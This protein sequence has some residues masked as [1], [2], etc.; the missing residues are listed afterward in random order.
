MRKAYLSIDHTVVGGCKTTAAWRTCIAA[1]EYLGQLDSTAVVPE[2]WDG[3]GPYRASAGSTF[4][5]LLKEK[6]VIFITKLK[7]K[8]SYRYI[9]YLL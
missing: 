7:K 6:F 9:Y 1:G 4:I 5:S 2:A 3:C 8:T